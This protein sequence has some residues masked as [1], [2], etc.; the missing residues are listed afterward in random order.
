M[1]ITKRD[2]SYILQQDGITITAL[3]TGRGWAVIGD[4]P[5]ALMGKFQGIDAIKTAFE[6]HLS[7]L[8]D[9]L[10]KEDN[11]LIDEDIPLEG[12][13]LDPTLRYGP[14]PRRT[15]TVAV[16]DLHI[17]LPLPKRKTN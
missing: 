17:L 8:R 15:I 12:T 16:K 14:P 10:S 9:S 1:E 2:N 4:T 6:R 13:I 3:N 7:T 5:P 11:P